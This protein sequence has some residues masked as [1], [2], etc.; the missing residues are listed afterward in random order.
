MTKLDFDVFSAAVS[1][2]NPVGDRELI[3]RGLKLQRIENLALTK[4]LRLLES[5]I[6]I[7]KSNQDQNDTID[8]T[9]NDLRK[10]EN[11]PNLPRL[12]TLLLANNRI[13]GI[14]SSISNYIPG[15]NAL[16]LN[17][18][19]IS[20][21]G[22]LSPLV[23]LEHLRYLSLIDN[24]VTL[25]KHYRLYVIHRCPNIRVLDYVKIR[26][27]ER[28]EAAA[29]FSGKDGTAL[30][31]ALAAKK[32]KRAEHTDDETGLLPAKKQPKLHQTRSSEEEERIREQIRDATTLEE[33]ARLE[34][35]LA[36]S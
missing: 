13:T 23:N 29:L 5:I 21:L 36:S 11:L 10:L 20:D 17:N 16:V 34:K 9:D 4:V 33:I 32:T 12:K 26:E 8:L 27:K 25:R 15:L 24:P 1:R 35:T 30:A 14:D 2:L 18:N 28:L 19:Q 3:L 22:D 7:T 31:N 6:T